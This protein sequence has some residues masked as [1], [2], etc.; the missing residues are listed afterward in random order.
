MHT[1]WSRNSS[2]QRLQYGSPLYPNMAH[3]LANRC[4]LLGLLWRR[5]R[6]R[7]PIPMEG[8]LAV[9]PALEVTCQCCMTS[10]PV[11]APGN[12]GGGVGAVGLSPMQNGQIS[13]GGCSGAGPGGALSM[14]AWWMASSGAPEAAK[15]AGG[16]IVNEFAPITSCR[17]QL[18]RWCTNGG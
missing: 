8:L 17:H 18:A 13:P 3:H 14:G 2:L 15:D 6:D 7:P 4:G 1:K 11:R 12:E 16:S 10:V 5:N 9:S